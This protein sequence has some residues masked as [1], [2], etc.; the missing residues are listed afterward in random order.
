MFTRTKHG[1]NKLAEQLN[2][3][4][5]TALA[6]H[7]NKSQARAHPRAG[8]IQ[9]RRR[10]RCWSRPTS[11]RAA[12]TSTS[13]RTSS[14]T[15]CR[16]CPRTTCTASAAPAAP[17][18]T[19]EAISLVCVDEHEFLRDIERL[20]KRQ[21][22]QEVIAGFEPDPARERNRSC[23]DKPRPVAR[24]RRGTGPAAA[25]PRRRPWP[26]RPASQRTGITSQRDC[27]QPR[28]Y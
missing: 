19:G 3:D 15:T 21:I 26:P 28:R 6:I 23:N 5:I 25:R 22:P 11:P 24:G 18:R 17:A 7:G 13:C 27:P 8:G 2:K 4:G 10:C 1:A 14:T 12:S 20:I 16:T 9:G